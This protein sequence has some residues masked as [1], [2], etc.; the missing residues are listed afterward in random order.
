[1][2][3]GPSLPLRTC[4]ACR[5]R[6]AKP[7]LIRLIAEGD[8]LL[9]ASNKHFGRSAYLCPNPACASGALQKGRLARALKRSI[10]EKALETL[11]NVLECKL[12]IAL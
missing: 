3:S 9:V 8:E 11:K 7:F 10:P 2:T 6:A 12:K 1:M 5:C 4:I